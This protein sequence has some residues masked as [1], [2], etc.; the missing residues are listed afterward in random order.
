MLR[1]VSGI[2]SLVHLTRKARYTISSQVMRWW[3]VDGSDGW[4]VVKYF[5][6]DG[7]WWWWQIMAMGY[8]E[9]RQCWQ[10]LLPI[11]LYQ[12][13]SLLAPHNRKNNKNHLK[14]NLDP[15]ICYHPLTLIYPHSLSLTHP[16][17]PHL[18]T[19]SAS[20]IQHQPAQLQVP[21]AWHQGT[22]LNSWWL[23]ISCLSWT[24]DVLVG[25]GG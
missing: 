19:D 16:R 22:L 9:Q 12:K 1:F 10:I 4:F 6:G 3:D 14:T 2:V 11:I 13:L 5:Y 7:R 8:G 18:P 20:P 24:L 21:C 25:G 17:Y 15:C 23:S